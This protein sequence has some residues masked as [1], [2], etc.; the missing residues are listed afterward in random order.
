M[1]RFL[2]G[3]KVASKV[4]P[5]GLI[6]GTLPFSVSGVKPKEV[7]MANRTSFT[8]DDINCIEIFLNNTL[9]D[10]ASSSQYISV[11]MTETYTIFFFIRWS[12]AVKLL[13]C[14]RMKIYIIYGNISSFI[15][16]IIKKLFIFISKYIVIHIYIL[17]S[18]Q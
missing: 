15:F 5:N 18:N 14:D 3:L 13:I 1:S 16:V 10:S 9:Q 8:N 7:K 17:Y 6:T 11:K 2:L 12:R 4:F